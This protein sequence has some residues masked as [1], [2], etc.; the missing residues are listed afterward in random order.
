M[1]V[2]IIATIVGGIIA[3]VS[4]ITSQ[5]IS[6]RSENESIR[7]KFIFT[8]CENLI[9][10]IRKYD[11]YCMD[12]NK[13][14]LDKTE[15]NKLYYESQYEFLQLQCEFRSPLLISDD[16]LQKRLSELRLASVKMTDEILK[17]ANS[18]YPIRINDVYMSEQTEVIQKLNGYLGDMMKD[19]VA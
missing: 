17:A 15:A 16:Y 7:R 6:R 10:A 12:M 2:D 3:A 5:Y 11:D 1:E 9:K 18:D 13:K 4:S 19:N 14:V 8:Q